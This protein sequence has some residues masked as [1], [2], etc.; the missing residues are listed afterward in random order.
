MADI[1]IAVAAFVSEIEAVLGERRDVVGS[2][3]DGVRVGVAGE[4]VEAVGK[5]FGERDLQRVIHGT[6]GIVEYVD[7]AEIREARATAAD[8]ATRS[9]AI[10]RVRP[11]GLFATG[12]IAI[13]ESAGGVDA[14]DADGGLGL[15]LVDIAVKIYAAVGDI[16]DLQS[17][18]GR[19]RL[20]DIDVP[21]RD[22]RHGEMWRGSKNKAGIAQA[23]P[24]A[25]A[26]FAGEHGAGIRIGHAGP[27]DQGRVFG[28]IKEVGD[29]AGS[30]S[31]TERGRGG[32]QI[33]TAAAKHEGADRGL[34]ENKSAAGAEYGFAGAENIPGKTEAWRNIVVAGGVGRA[35]PF[36]D[37][38]DSRM[39]TG[40]EEIG[41][42]VP[43][44][45]DWRSN[46]IAQAHI[47]G[48]AGLDAVAILNKETNRFEAD[49]AGRVAIKLFPFFHVAGG[50]ILERI[51][52]DA[53][54]TFGSAEIVDG[55]V[56]VI[57]AEAQGM[58]S[59]GE[60][61]GIGN[62]FGAAGKGF[63]RP[64]GIAAHVA[65]GET[66]AQ[67]DAR[68]AEETRV[69]HTGVDAVTGIGID[70]VIER[71]DRFVK[72]VVTEAE[73]IDP[74]RV[75]SPGPIDAEHLGNGLGGRAPLRADGY[76]VLFD[77]VGVGVDEAA[78]NG[79]LRIQDVVGLGDDVV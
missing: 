33:Q 58:F 53:A 47:D 27:I 68:K 25:G 43:G 42:Q 54:T 66:G 51:E 40:G 79:V 12:E 71:Q 75:G 6:R 20:L 35:D 19:Q 74:A 60:R 77:F 18:V 14:G 23:A 36:A 56:A 8:A 21:I 61:S 28:K 72:V 63:E 48:E 26:D 46:V 65:A 64:A 10:E 62:I 76:G 70:V 2:G 9:R 17:G 73:L 11:R 4:Q 16:G 3:V 78:G 15:I 50:E 44:V 39:W 52:I 55:A 67:A 5:A 41:E 45:F 69:G 29:V 49:V 57:A 30:G 34:F 32:I 1:E 13:E 38:N 31:D 22:V 37:L 59:A 24:A 7:L